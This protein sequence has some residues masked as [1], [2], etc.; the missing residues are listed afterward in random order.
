MEQFKQ[1]F[2]DGLVIASGIFGM[3]ILALMIAM[4]FVGITFSELYCDILCLL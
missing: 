4:S 3:I 2:Y 1:S